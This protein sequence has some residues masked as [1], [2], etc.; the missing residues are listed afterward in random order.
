[1]PADISAALQTTVTKT[2]S[3]NGA[4]FDLI[5]RTPRRGLVARFAF[6]SFASVGTAGATFT[7]SIE[8]SDDGSTFVPCASGPPL[9]GATAANAS[10]APVFVTFKTNKRYIRPV[11][12]I[13]AT[14]TP[15]C[16]YKADI[17]SADQ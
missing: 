7:P 1:M 11:V 13:T 5:T 17:M 2:A 4:A 10:A 16:I 8:Q 3:F 12:T 14:G 6:A 15:T 9:T